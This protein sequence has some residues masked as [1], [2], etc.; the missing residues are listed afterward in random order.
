MTVSPEGGIKLY[1]LVFGMNTLQLPDRKTDLIVGSSA[2]GKKITLYKCLLTNIHR[3]IVNKG[4]CTEEFEVISRF[5][6][7]GTHFNKVQDITFKSLYV[8]Y[9]NLEKWADISGFKIAPYQKDTYLIKYRLPKKIALKT[10]DDFQISVSFSASYPALTHPQTEAS[11]EQ[12]AWLTFTPSISKNLDDFL[13]VIRIMQN[14][15]T[16]AMSE[17]TY[18]AVVEGQSESEKDD[19]G[20]GAVFYLPIKIVFIQSF[21]KS[22]ELSTLSTFDMLFTLK[23]IIRKKRIVKNWFEKTD[24]LEPVCDLYFSTLYQKGMYLNNELLNLTQALESYHRRTKKNL[25]VSKKQHEKRIQMILKKTPIKHKE[26]LESKLTYS[27]EPTFRKRLR[28]I[29]N[30][31]P[32]A[33]SD[34]LGTKDSFVDVT[35]N[36]RNYWT[37]FDDIKPNTAMGFDLFY[38]VLKLKVLVMTCLLEEMGFAT[39]EIERLMSKALSQIKR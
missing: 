25:E 32:T 30:E 2:D 4:A 6:F 13:K 1:L 23:E 18:P 5:V 10:G 37:H 36:T 15:L 16:L 8:R 7:V 38:L 24:I 17:P 14:F 33:I 29:C 19:L 9:L 20:D 34:K 28:D 11:I 35:V 31:C 26:W 21:Y 3:H 27:N 39:Q 12:N 22:P